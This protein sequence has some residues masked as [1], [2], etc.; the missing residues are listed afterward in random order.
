MRHLFL[1]FPGKTVMGPADCC[2][3]SSLWSQEPVFKSWLTDSVMLVVVIVSLALLASVSL[4]HEKGVMA[5]GT[6]GA[7]VGF[8][9]FL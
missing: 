4:S 2:F 3:A 5:G 9:E 1:W 8:S 7:A 6:R